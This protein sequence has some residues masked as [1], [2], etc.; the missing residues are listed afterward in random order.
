MVNSYLAT[1]D[2]AP[3]IIFYNGPAANAYTSA[4]YS[5][6]PVTATPTFKIDGLYTQIGWNQSNCQNYINSRLATPSYLSIAVTFSLCSR[7]RRA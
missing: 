3:Q 7:H 5:L 6:Y 4:R 1:D 2:I